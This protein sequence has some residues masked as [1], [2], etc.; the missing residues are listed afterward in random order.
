MPPDERRDLTMHIFAVS[1]GLVG[2]CLTGIGL[3]RVISN[4]TRLESWGDN[5]LALDAALFVSASFL[6]FWSFKVSRE[7]LR[8]R[9]AWIVEV[10]FIVGLA[11]M[12]GVCAMLV[13]TFA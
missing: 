5:L 8:R 4:Q 3:L 10:L 2:V 6:A 1:A 13:Y 7:G 11:I 12:V 9:L